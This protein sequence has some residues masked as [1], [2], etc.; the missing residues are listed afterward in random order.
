M[1]SVDIA[2]PCY[3][4][5]RYLRQ[6]VESVLAQGLP[7]LRILIIDNAST[8]DSVAIARQ[9]AAEDARIEVVTRPVN[10]GPHASFNAGVDWARAD[11]FM[12]LCADDLLTPGA[13]QRAV[14]VMERHPEVS[15]AYGTDVHRGDEAGLSAAAADAAPHGADAPW[16]LA[17]GR[18]F[19]EDRCRNPERY[20][21]HGMVLVRTAAQ[22]QAGHYRPQLPH[23]DDF[24][25]LLRLARLGGVASTPAAQGIKRMHAANRTNDYLAER[26]RALTELLA[27]LESFFANE[28][29]ALAD[30]ERLLRMARRGL[31]E[32]AYWCG[33]KDLV[34]GRRSGARLLRLAFRLAPA[35]AVVPPVNYLL[36]L[37]RPLSYVGRVIAEMALPNVAQTPAGP[38]AGAAARAG[39]GRVL[40][41]PRRAGRR[42]GLDALPPSRTDP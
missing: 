27:A 21:A 39:G 3:Q 5:G 7:E 38:D 18:Q 32:R 22:K 11:Y 33:V 1:A 15:F 14:A 42:D 30:A 12:V 9:L 28:G 6:C 34:R 29:R 19:I 10:L 8:D 35:T 40:R 16:T 24:E 25:M 31:A 26:T 20:I 13:L 36:R 37:D 2:V 4:Y 41:L 23:S 17:T